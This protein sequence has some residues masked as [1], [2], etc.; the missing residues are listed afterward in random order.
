MASMVRSMASVLGTSWAP[1]VSFG[2]LL[3]VLNAHNDPFVP[4]QHLPRAHDVG[5]CVT[6]WQPAHGGHV[7]FAGGRFPGQVLALPQ[8]V[9]GWMRGAAPPAAIS[10]TMP[11]HG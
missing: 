3:L 7:G 1:A 2:L 9:M 8:A 4:W 6:L 10:G 5:P 11:T